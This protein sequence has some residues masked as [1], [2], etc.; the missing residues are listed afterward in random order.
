MNIVE[1]LDNDFERQLNKLINKYGEE[2]TKI[3]GFSEDQLN[4][5]EFIDNFTDNEGSVADA[6]IDP[7]ANISCKDIRTLLDEMSKP[8]QKLLSFNKIY[9][10]MKKKYGKKIANEWLE[11]EFSGALYCHDASSTSFFSY[12]YAYELQNLAE[13]GLYFLPKTNNEPP[14][15]MTTFFAHLREFVAWVSCRSAGACALPSFFIYS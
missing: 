6:T 11:D 8:K 1:N 12:C 5:T 14:Q 10:E 3:N 4:D 15:H 2:I 7:S 13:K 9:Y